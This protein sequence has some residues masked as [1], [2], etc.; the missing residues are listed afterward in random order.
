ME[1]L[2]PQLDTSSDV[3][4]RRFVLQLA[5]SLAGVSAGERLMRTVLLV[6]APN[7]TGATPLSVAGLARQM[8]ADWQVS[9]P[10]W[11]EDVL[12]LALLDSATTV[13]EDSVVIIVSPTNAVDVP[14]VTDLQSLVNRSP[15]TTR[16]VSI[17]PKLGDVP[18]HS[19]VMGVQGRAGRIATLD[20]FIPFFVCRL[21]YTAG[22]VYP[23]QGVLYHGSHDDHWQVWRADRDE[24]GFQLIADY[25][26]R[27]DPAEITDAFAAY[28]VR[29]EKAALA[30]SNATS[31]NSI[32]LPMLV[33]GAVFCAAIGAHY[34][35][36]V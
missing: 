9:R 4:C 27:P 36:L 23:V 3:Y 14:T 15:A 12:R 35:G 22:T 11:P 1:L 2:V 18:G 29:R 30:A 34:I 10:Q 16:F 6:Q 7:A 25:E 17:N 33:S 31:Q 8:A 28:R 13:D 20:S 32:P 21:L 26:S 5:W 24:K 19:G